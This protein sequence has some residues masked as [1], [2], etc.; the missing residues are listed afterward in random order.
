MACAITT[1]G[2]EPT[3][4]RKISLIKTAMGNV[5]TA[6]HQDHA[7]DQGT[8]DQKARVAEA[9]RAREKA[10]AADKDISIGM[11]AQIRA[12]HLRPL[13][14]KSNQQII[15]EAVSKPETASYYIIAQ[16]D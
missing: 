5:I 13:N 2:K 11:V 15:K 8:A 16:H 12:A 7:K 3:V 1:K 9:V 14:Q 4:R 6:E 10:M